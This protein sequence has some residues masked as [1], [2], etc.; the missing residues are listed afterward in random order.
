MVDPAQRQKLGVYLPPKLARI[1]RLIPRLLPPGDC[2][3]VLRF[4]VVV[5]QELLF[6]ARIAARL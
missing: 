2:S 5:L 6:L 4:T 1:A 3:I